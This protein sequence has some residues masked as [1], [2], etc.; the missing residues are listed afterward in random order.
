M[1]KG[2]FEQLVTEYECWSAVQKLWTISVM[3]LA[4]I[5]V[6]LR[7]NTSAV[8]KE[9]KRDTKEDKGKSMMHAVDG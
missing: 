3:Q 6:Q 4:T 5:H 8:S 7:T 9:G 1:Y 2:W